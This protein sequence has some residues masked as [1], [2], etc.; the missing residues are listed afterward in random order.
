[1]AL[2][3][4]RGVIPVVKL[5]RMMST[6]QHQPFGEIDS[7][8]GARDRVLV[9]V[10]V[11]VVLCLLDRATSSS[12]GKGTV[13]TVRNV[14]SLILSMILVARIGIMGMINSLLNNVKLC[15]L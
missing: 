12:L 11:M 8:H 6:L 4:T 5:G 7:W 2:L 13:R 1:M 9:Q 3:A 14:S 15:L 10:V